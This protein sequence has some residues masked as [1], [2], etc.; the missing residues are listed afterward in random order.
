[1]IH[2]EV[3]KQCEGH[4]FFCFAVEVDLVEVAN[5]DWSRGFRDRVEE[6]GVFRPASRG[7]NFLDRFGN[8]SA[9]GV[10]N[11]LSGKVDGGGD[12]VLIGTTFRATPFYQVL[13]VRR[14]E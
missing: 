10:S 13:D 12:D 1:M 6:S 2:V 5:L 4:G 14:V 9:V 8:K 11:A 3:S 7:Q